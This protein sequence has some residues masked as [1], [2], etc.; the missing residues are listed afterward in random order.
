MDPNYAEHDDY[1]DLIRKTWY[2]ENGQAAKQQDIIPK[3]WY[4]QW[5]ANGQLELE[6]EG[7]PFMDKKGTWVEY[8]ENGQKRAEGE[9]E[10]NKKVGVWKNWN[11]KAWLVS[12][13]TYEWNV[14]LRDSKIYDYYPD[15]SI[16]SQGGITRKH[17]NGHWEYFTQAGKKYR[18]ENYKLG[19]YS[20]NR[21]FIAEF[22]E[23]YPDDK[24]KL[25]G[26]DGKATRFYY[27]SGG[28]KVAE[29]QLV[30]KKTRGRHEYISKEGELTINPAYEEKRGGGEFLGYEFNEGFPIQ[31]DEFF[32]EGKKKTSYSFCKRCTYVP[33]EELRELN[34]TVGKTCTTCPAYTRA[35]ERLSLPAMT[36]LDGTQEGWYE[37]GQLRYQFDY[38]KGCLL[39]EAKEWREDGTQIYQARFTSDK[40]L[41]DLYKG[42]KCPSIC[43]SG[44]WY[45]ADGK[46]FEYQHEWN[47]KSFAI[48]H[49]SGDFS[50][51]VAEEKPKKV[52]EIESEAYLEE[53]R[54]LVE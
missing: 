16:R 1:K 50:N 46:A 17:K 51:L 22:T 8:H 33:K 38:S 29:I 35:Y 6:G 20:G 21:F 36:M 27:G 28:S 11:E 7:K 54:K 31:L 44:T 34:E 5:Y 9:Y 24:V 42:E 32:A 41:E 48:A 30:Y 40:Y 4:K 26:T 19:P 3:R 12:E 18:D 15:G 14:G 25:K 47:S 13:E 37:N 10:K 53:F 43:A 39:G 23:W 45:R 52:I 2:H 49:K